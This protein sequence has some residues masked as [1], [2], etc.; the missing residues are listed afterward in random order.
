MPNASDYYVGLMSGTSADGIDAVAVDF[1]G[2]HPSIVATHSHTIPDEIQQVIY[3]LMRPGDSE[4]DLLGQLDQQLATLFADAALSVIDKAGLSSNQITA[5]G[6]HG[7]TIRHRP[8]GQVPHPFTLQIADPSVIAFNTGITTVADFRRKD[9]AAG[10]QGA[11]LAPAIH[12]AVF[13]HPDIERF[14]VNIGGISNI[15]HL[16]RTADVIGFDTGP[17]NGLMNEWIKKHQA[18]EYDDNGRWSASGTPQPQLLRELLLH[19]YFLQPAPKSTGREEFTLDWVESVLSS[20]SEIPANDVQATLRELTTQSI[21][22][23]IQSQ[24]HTSR[25][26]VYICGGGAHNG[27]LMGS[28]QAK[29][30]PNAVSSTEDLGLHPDWVEGVCFAWLARQTLNRRHG[31]IATVTGARHDVVL[32]GVYYV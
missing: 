24:A 23:H 9:M 3:R 19:P 31:N 29:L 4:I 28:L 5:I 2:D 21:A 10:G 1:S 20:F 6:S 14:I 15:T 26:E 11:P 8:L 17:G 7:Q 27:A 30:N 25:Y 22:E 16:H 18:L 12:N 32:G 13:R